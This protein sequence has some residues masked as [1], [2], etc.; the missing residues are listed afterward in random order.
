V[1]FVLVVARNPN[2]SFLSV[3]LIS[4]KAMRWFHLKKAAMT[5]GLLRIIQCGGTF[6]CGTKRPLAMYM[7]TAIV[8]SNRLEDLRANV[9]RGMQG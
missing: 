2:S 3:V 5:P 8:D 9:S 1:S 7:H 6:R 4:L